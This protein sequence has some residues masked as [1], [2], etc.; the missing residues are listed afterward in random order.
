MAKTQNPV[1]AAAAAAKPVA[2]RGGAAV[3]TVQVQPG[4]V[5]RTKAPH[6]QAWWATVAAQATM[7]PMPVAALCAAPHSVPSHFVGYCL[8]RGYLQ[9]A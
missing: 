5:Y 3:A 7:H 8:R 4:A 6:N 2:L 1:A 9:G